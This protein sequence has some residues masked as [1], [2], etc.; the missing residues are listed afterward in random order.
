MKPRIRSGTLLSAL[1]AVSL[2]SVGT[3]V[4]AE[5]DEKAVRE[6]A[7]QFYSALNAMFTGALESMKKVWSHAEDVTYMGPGG[8]F[9]VGWSEVLQDWEKQAAMKLGGKVEAV[10]MRLTVGHDLA[11]TQNYEKGEN[12]GKDGKTLTVLIRA[13]N[14]FRKEK[15]AWKMISH[16]TDLLPHVQN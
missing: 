8:G 2:F 16:H 12:K 15:G 4:G 11:I 7:A 13:T 3:A 1:A 6:A 10:D 9:R 14:V 5:G